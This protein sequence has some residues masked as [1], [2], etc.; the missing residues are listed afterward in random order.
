MVVSEN[1]P[2]GAKLEKYYRP[3]FSCRSASSVGFYFI[4]KNGYWNQNNYDLYRAHVSFWISRIIIKCYLL[5]CF[6]YTISPICNI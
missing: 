4:W 3:C 6:F 2:L 5:A 1:M